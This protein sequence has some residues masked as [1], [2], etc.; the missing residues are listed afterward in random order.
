MDRSPSLKVV[1]VLALAQ[2]GFALL[3][4]YNWVQIGSNL[5]GQGLLLLP[6]VGVMAYMRGLFVSI[7]ALLYILFGVGGLLGK[8]WGWWPGLT[9]AVINLLLVFSAVVQGESLIEGLVWSVVPVMMIV[10]FFS[11]KEQHALMH[12]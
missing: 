7:V 1:A 10:S 11:R 2:G 12:A 5:F 3:R 9:A 6:I 8:S 4:A